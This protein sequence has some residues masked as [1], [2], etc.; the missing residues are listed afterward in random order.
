M[1]MRRRAFGDRPS[2][3]NN[4]RPPKIPVEV[5]VLFLFPRMVTLFARKVGYHPHSWENNF[6]T[7]ATPELNG[8]TQLGSNKALGA[9]P[10]DDR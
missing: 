3:S 2:Q 4:Y 5:G 1:P 8:T 6:G 9:V 7:Q 10:T